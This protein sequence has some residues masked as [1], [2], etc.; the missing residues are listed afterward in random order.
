MT[1]QRISAAAAI[2]N[3]LNFV[4]NEWLFVKTTNY[5][6]LQKVKKESAVIRVLMK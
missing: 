4:N 6:V 1:R 3:V 2:A 5:S